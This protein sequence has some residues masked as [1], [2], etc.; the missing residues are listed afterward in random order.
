M[1]AKL[2]AYPLPHDVGERW[3]RE[4]ATERGQRARGKYKPPYR[5]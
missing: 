5:P 1:G 4:A 3:R 2:D